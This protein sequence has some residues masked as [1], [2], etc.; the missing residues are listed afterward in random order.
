[1]FVTVRG[2]SAVAGQF[3]KSD[4]RHE[5]RNADGYLRDILSRRMDQ[6]EIRCPCVDDWRGVC[7]ASA[8][9]G[10]TSQDLKTGYLWRNSLLAADGLLVGVTVSTVAIGATL[11]LRTKD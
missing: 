3:L 10:A 7:I 4:Q 2:A 6:S 8:I 1:L 11:N 9:A 5:H